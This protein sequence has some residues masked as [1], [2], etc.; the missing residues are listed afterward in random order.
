MV[1]KGVIV[2]Y[3]LCFRSYRY[4]FFLYI[5]DSVIVN[6]LFETKHSNYAQ[7]LEN[8]EVSL[9]EIGS[10]FRGVEGCVRIH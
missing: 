10:G 3:F 7:L 5:C 8:F 4:S 9:S 6:P 2:L 1:I